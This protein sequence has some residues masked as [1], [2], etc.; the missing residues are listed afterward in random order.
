M[1][2]NINNEKSF[3]NLLSMIVRPAAGFAILI[4]ALALTSS[5]QVKTTSTTASPT[6]PPSAP[7]TVVNT[8]ANPVPVAVAGT[9]NVG[10]TLNVSISDNS[11]TNP[12]QVHDVDNAPRTPYA[13]TKRLS[14]N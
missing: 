4:G 1:N 8:T 2:K 11:A 13:Q 7:V 14:F 3:K 12:L 6:T 5:A 10:G 9:V